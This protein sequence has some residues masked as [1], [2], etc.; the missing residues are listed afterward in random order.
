MTIFLTLK[1]TTLSC[2]RANSFYA[3]KSKCSFGQSFI[4]YLGHI[5]SF[6]G[7]EPDPAKIVASSLASAF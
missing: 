2:L 3:N 1:Q 7:V 4:D 5:I 6:K